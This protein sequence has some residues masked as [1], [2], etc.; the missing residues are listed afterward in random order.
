MPKCR[1]VLRAATGLQ[2][3][4]KLRAHFTRKHKITLSMQAA[5]E[6]RVTMEAGEC[7]VRVGAD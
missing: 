5:L 7:P 4:Q 2:E 1:A 3:I 6:F